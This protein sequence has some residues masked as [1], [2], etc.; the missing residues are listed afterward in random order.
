[1]GS[2]FGPLC[3]NIDAERVL[4]A[5]ADA[6]SLTIMLVLTA[7]DVSLVSSTFSPDDLTRLMALVFVRLSSR[8]GIVSPQRT[9]IE[10]IHHTALFMPSRIHEFGS[11][12]KVV[13]VPKPKPNINTSTSA[14]SPEGVDRNAVTFPGRHKGLPASTLVLDEQT[15]SAR[16]LVNATNL[17]ALR[18][19]AGILLFT[20]FVCNVA[21]IGLI[22]DFCSLFSFL[23]T[24]PPK[25]LRRV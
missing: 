16:A 17:T 5:C 22:Y 15:G 20:K 25:S 2:V 11:A 21:V 23:R 13:S 12:V 8:V 19:A 4:S 14:L 10:G 24:L 9:S 7:A 3:P 1:M 18:N 6:Q